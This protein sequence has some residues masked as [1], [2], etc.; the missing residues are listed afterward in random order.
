MTQAH[1]SSRDHSGASA[2]AGILRASLAVDV[3]APG[4][5]IVRLAFGVASP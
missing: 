5:P 4:T 1:A 2:I 3:V